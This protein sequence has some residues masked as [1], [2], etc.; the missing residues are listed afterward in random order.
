MG[1]WQRAQLVAL[2][3]TAQP[4]LGVSEAWAQRVT[5]RARL[6]RPAGVAAVGSNVPD[7]RTART[8]ERRRLGASPDTI[9][10][11]HIDTPHPSRMARHVTHA[12]NSVAET[13]LP[14][15]LLNL[16]AEA[17]G[18]R[19]LDGAVTVHTPGRL[20]ETALARAI[21]ASD[22]FLSPCTD[23]VS[24]RRTSLMAALQQARAVV[25]TESPT[26]D[27]VLR[28]GEVR[29]VPVAEVAGFAEAVVQLANDR[30]EREAMAHAGR[31]LY[32]QRFAWPALAA[33]LT[34]TLRAAVLD[35]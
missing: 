21:A 14:V 20:D 4:V 19:G 10:L 12:A 3:R 18:V 29:L 25:A 7:A 24:V 32:E 35:P 27:A 9:V 11:S 1:A 23:G 34:R 15:M 16:G 8:A 33:D 5:R 17:P 13:G 26:T 28:G 31:G 2:A 30:A 6:A 22:V